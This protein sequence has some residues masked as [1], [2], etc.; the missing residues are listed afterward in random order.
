MAGFI[1]IV[2]SMEKF[3]LRGLF[4]RNKLDIV[5]EKQIHMAI[6]FMKFVC[7]SCFN[8]GDQLIGKFIALDVGKLH[9]RLI[10]MEIVADGHEKMGLSQTGA[11]V[12][13]ERVELFP[14]F[15]ATAIAAA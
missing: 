10:F 3:F 13:K 7:C 11:A 1:D 4:S 9:P 12:N 14:G 8:G 2:K 5:Y 6:F 15:S